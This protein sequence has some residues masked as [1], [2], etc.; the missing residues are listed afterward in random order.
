MYYYMYLYTYIHT[1]IGIL[2]L[3]IPNLWPVPAAPLLAT[4][5]F[6][7]LPVD[8][9][10]RYNIW[11]M[12][13]LYEYLYLY[14]TCVCILICKYIHIYIYNVYTYVY[15]LFLLLHILGIYCVLCWVLSLPWFD[16][17]LPLLQ[18]TTVY[19][20]VYTCICIHMYI[21][22]HLFIN[23]Y[24]HMSIYLCINMYIY[25]SIFYYRYNWKAAYNTMAVCDIRDIHET[26]WFPW[27]QSKFR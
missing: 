9:S 16:R 23:I 24:I 7:H 22:V 20:Y 3:A 18:V 4:E 17:N 1:Y 19:I 26:Q 27:I 6:P 11:Y 5:L 10:R 12:K 21:Y 8:I 25:V 2:A 14:I 15:V 13:Y